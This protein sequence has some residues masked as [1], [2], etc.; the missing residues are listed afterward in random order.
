MS[1]WRGLA[2]PD[3][4]DDPDG[5]EYEAWCCGCSRMCYSDRACYCCLTS[6]VERLERAEAAIARVLEL[7]DQRDA[8]VAASDPLFGPPLTLTVAEVRRA[9][10]GAE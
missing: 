1:E 7:C 2:N 6:E 10:G 8:E 4:H 5:N 3:W 9:L